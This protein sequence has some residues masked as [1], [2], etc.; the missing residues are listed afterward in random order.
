M[1]CGRVWLHPLSVELWEKGLERYIK[2][3]EPL[4]EMALGSRG[5]VYGLSGHMCMA[6]SGH[7]VAP[8]GLAVGEAVG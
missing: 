7:R 2:E 8:V 6:L 4:L 5:A 3:K 1:T